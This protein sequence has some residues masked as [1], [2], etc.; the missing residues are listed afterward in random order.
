MY[1]NFDHQKQWNL[2]AERQNF[3]RENNISKKILFIDMDG[4]IADFD[5]AVRC[6]EPTL[7]TKEGKSYEERAAMVDKVCESNPL[8][9]HFLEPIDGAIE[10]VNKLFDL[11]EVYF[12]STPMW[13]VPDS[14]TG[15]RIWLEKHFGEAAK[16]RLILTHRKDLCIGDYLIDDRLR[17]GV[18]EFKG[19]H[20][21]FGT[22]G[23]E[24]WDRVLPMMVSFAT[25]LPW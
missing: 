1:P 9:F 13:N 11:Y 8:I 16:K 3:K 2:T 6:I 14:F 24:G 17:H 20:I 10:A 12:L 18:T 21:H 4:V 15:K 23:V 7:C 25:P 22:P 5:K 19:M